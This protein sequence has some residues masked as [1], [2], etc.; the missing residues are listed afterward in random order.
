MHTGTLELVDG[1]IRYRLD[2]SVSWE[3]PIAVVR[4]I[5]EATNDHGP[6]FDDYF[7]CFATDAN[8]WYE[9]SFYAKGRAEFLESLSKVLEC[10]LELKLVGKTDYESNVLWPPHLAGAKMF[11]YR[12]VRPKTC[13]GRLFGPWSNSQ[14]FSDEVVAELQGRISRC[15]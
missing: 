3:L 9:A 8:N 13:I 12:P 7:F 10:E 5:G 15:T 6:F 11:S 14:W 2:G 4:V 1:S